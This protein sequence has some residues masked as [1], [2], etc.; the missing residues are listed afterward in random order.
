MNFAAKYIPV[1]FSQLLDVCNHQQEMLEKYEEF[2]EKQI[3]SNILKEDFDGVTW[4]AYG[5]GSFKRVTIPQSTFMLRCDSS[6]LK[7]WKLLQYSRPVFD[8]DYFM[9][10]AIIE[11]GENNAK[12]N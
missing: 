3:M 9:N 1:T 10:A 6:T 4:D 8:K 5:W 12:A 2:I 11:E 7:A